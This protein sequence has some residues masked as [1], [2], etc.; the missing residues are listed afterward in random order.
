VHTY[1]LN[2]LSLPRASFLLLKVVHIFPLTPEPVRHQRTSIEEVFLDRRHFTQRRTEFTLAQPIQHQTWPWQTRLPHH[3]PHHH[4]S[5]SK[6]VPA[7]SQSSPKAANSRVPN[8]CN[9]HQPPTRTSS[10]SSPKWT[11]TKPRADALPLLPQLRS[12]TTGT[13][14]PVQRHR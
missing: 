12:T 5:E 8:S 4:A 11:R 10:I 7:A 1:A 13:Q 9:G 3:R 6:L 2:R 14:T